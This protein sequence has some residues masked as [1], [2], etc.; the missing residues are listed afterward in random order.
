[1]HP[2]RRIC[3]GHNSKRGIC[4]E[5]PVVTS[6]RKRPLV[7]TSRIARKFKRR[8]ISGAPRGIAEENRMDTQGND[9]NVNV[10]APADDDT[11]EFC[12]GDNDDD[13]DDVVHDEVDE[14]HES[15]E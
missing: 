10:E 4:G 7:S 15:D 9:E 13:N 8:R 11:S 12:N 14:V 1:M 5:G 2:C 3:H 6:L